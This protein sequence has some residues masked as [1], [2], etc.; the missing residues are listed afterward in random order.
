MIYLIHFQ[1]PI[2][3]NIVLIVEIHL[4]WKIITAQVNL[5]KDF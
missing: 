5:I 2:N 4:D 3:I 1:A